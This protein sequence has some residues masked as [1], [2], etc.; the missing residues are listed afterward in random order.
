MCLPV[1]ASEICS[2]RFRSSSRSTFSEL[3]Y[4]L[5]SW[6]LGETMDKYVLHACARTCRMDTTKRESSIR[7][8]SIIV[9]PKVWKDE[10]GLLSSRHCSRQT[11]SREVIYKDSLQR[12]NLAVESRNSVHP[13]WEN[14]YSFYFFRKL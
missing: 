2:T 6:N 9:F 7:H 13:N 1:L 3:V 10:N 11:G 4:R 5:S 14:K 8:W 12:R